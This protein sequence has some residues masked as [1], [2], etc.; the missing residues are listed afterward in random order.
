MCFWSCFHRTKTNWSMHFQCNYWLEL[1]DSIN[2]EEYSCLVILYFLQRENMHFAFNE[3][4]RYHYFLS[5]RTKMMLDIF[6]ITLEWSVY[7]NYTCGVISSYLYHI[8]DFWLRRQTLIT[9]FTWYFFLFIWL[10]IEMK[11]AAPAG[12]SAVA[13]IRM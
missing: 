3:I 10:C 8:V 7:A 12:S 1:Q 2:W 5:I 9:S 4:N 11:G 13:V 6:W